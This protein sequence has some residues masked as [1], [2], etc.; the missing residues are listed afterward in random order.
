VAGPAFDPRD[1]AV[2][3]QVLQEK[4]HRVVSPIVRQASMGK[5]AKPTM[6]TLKSNS[7]KKSLPLRDSETLPSNDQAAT[8]DALTA[9]IRQGMESGAST[10]RSTTPK[11]HVDAS[12]VRMPFQGEPGSPTSVYTDTTATNKRHSIPFSS[13]KGYDPRESKPSTITEREVDDYEKSNFAFDLP[14][15][16][17]H[18]SAHPIIGDE[19]PGMGDRIPPGKRPPKLNMDAVRDAEARGSMTSL[20]DLIKRATKL[21]SNLDR[22]RTA[23]RL[24]HLDWFGSNEKLGANNN[25]VRDSTY[26][27][28]LAAFPQPDGTGTPGRDRPPTMWP[29]G[30]KQFMASKS[31]L[32]RFNETKTKPKRK[33]CG[34]SPP[35]FVLVLV[36][37]V[38][39]IVAAVLV[40]VFLIVLPKQRHSTNVAECPSTQPCKNGGFSVVAK[41]LCACICVDGFT[42]SD[43][44]TQRDPECVTASLA[45]G[46]KEYS[47]A[48]IGSSLLPLLKDGQTQFQI[49]LNITNILSTFAYNNLSCASENSLVDFGTSSTSAKAKRFVMLPGMI[50]AEPHI[51]ILNLPASETEEHKRFVIV[52]ELEPAAEHMQLVHVPNPTLQPRQDATK[53]ANG[54]VF[55]TSSDAVTAPTEAASLAQAS[56]TATTT[57]PATAS[58]SSSTPAPTSSIKATD[59]QLNFAATVVLYVF[60]SNSDVSVAVGA[61]QAIASYL[62]VDNPSNHTVVVVSGE[63][64]LEADFNMFQI[65]FANGTTIGGS[66]S[67]A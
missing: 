56:G 42:G 31:S 54:I 15:P 25:R 11:S 30:E 3:G 58:A 27:D 63:Q 48:T 59:G 26:S 6:T 43:C 16:G 46:M 49:P 23:S 5:K 9:A 14:T 51:P 67:T 19:K 28:V 37:L 60:Q 22:G 17:S 1:D 2:S 35:V 65:R 41:N 38:L 57:A 64:K 61:H 40:P 12:I 24:G 7:S 20:S 33:C 36:I 47:N 32:G 50:S 39:L 62:Q 10:T 53:S 44:S 8:M 66:N 18:S 21:A 13:Y 29:H 45:D 55:A 4:G 34:M 52:D